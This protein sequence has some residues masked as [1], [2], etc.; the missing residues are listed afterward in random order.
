[1]E[2]KKNDF[3]S[4]NISGKCLRTKKFDIKINANIEVVKRLILARLKIR[5]NCIIPNVESCFL[6]TDDNIKL[7]D[8]MKIVIYILI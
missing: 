5:G 2:S 6:I 7:N 4:I 1:M 3:I 8:K